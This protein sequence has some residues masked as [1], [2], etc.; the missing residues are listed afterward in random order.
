MSLIQDVAEWVVRSFSPK[1]ARRAI[2]QGG[3]RLQPRCW[4]GKK[5]EIRM[6]K[7]SAGHLAVETNSK[8]EGKEGI[9]HKSID[10]SLT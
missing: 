2:S 5:H 3:I 1:I 4:F 6:S 10:V 8:Y 9:R 7:S